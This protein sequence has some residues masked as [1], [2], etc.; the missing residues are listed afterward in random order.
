MT[1]FQSCVLGL[2]QGITEFLPISSSAHLI[3]FPWFFGWQDPGL[4]FDVFLHLGT[5]LAVF[6]YFFQDWVRLIAAGFAS[7]RERRI[8][9]DYERQ[10]FWMLVVGNIPAVLAGVVLHDWIATIFRSPMLISM[11]L[12]VVGFLLYWV[13][14]SSPAIKNLREMTF[15]DALMVGIAQACAL[16]PGVSRSG[17]TMTMARW[18]GV[19]RT[20]SARFSFLLAFPITLGASLFEMRDISN[21]TAQGMPV[22]HLVGGFMCSLIAGL[23]AIHFLMQVLQAAS[24]RLFGFYRIALAAVIILWSVFSG[25]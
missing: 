16:V 5:L 1:F 17:A 6:L 22:S 3:L 10:I 8:Y 12:A 15:K 21:I 23:M 25:N 11:T 18:L 14:E 13:D 2:V 7:I 24:F 9:G 19:R 20:E 4:A